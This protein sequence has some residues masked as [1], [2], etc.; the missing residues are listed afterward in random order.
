MCKVLC[1]LSKTQN[2]SQSLLKTQRS[3]LHYKLRYFARSES[4]KI[5]VQIP[6]RRRKPWKRFRQALNHFK[7]FSNGLPEFELI[8]VPAVFIQK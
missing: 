8:A 2:A 3:I 7:R 4:L 1:L 5:T 6:C